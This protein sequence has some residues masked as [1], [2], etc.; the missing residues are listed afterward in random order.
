MATD[1][2]Q[3]NVGKK[4]LNSDLGSFAIVIGDETTYFISPKNFSKNITLFLYN[5]LE[6]GIPFIFEYDDM[7]K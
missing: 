3:E 7:Q 5:A 1:A 6:I 2:A 4:M